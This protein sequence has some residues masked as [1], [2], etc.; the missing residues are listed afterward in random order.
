MLV[1][2]VDT[3]DHSSAGGGYD[4]QWRHPDTIPCGGYYDSGL[5]VPCEDNRRHFIPG[6]S[7]SRPDRN[8]REVWTNAQQNQIKRWARELGSFGLDTLAKQINIQRSALGTWLRGDRPPKAGSFLDLIIFAR[9]RGLTV[10]ANLE[11]TARRR[12][13]V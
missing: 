7:L 8:E 6:T 10:D 5:S 11:V 4:W 1:M 2:D 9:Q 13:G 12:K 3:A